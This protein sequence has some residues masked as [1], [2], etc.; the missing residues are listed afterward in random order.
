MRPE[1]PLRL[2]LCATAFVWSP[3]AAFLGILLC[4]AV[5]GRN[6]RTFSLLTTPLML[7]CTAALVYAVFALYRSSYGARWVFI[8]LNGLAA[9][10]A[11]FLVCLLAR[12]FPLPWS[13]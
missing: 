5:A 9:V 2:R 10:L 13:P 4:A 1:P 11:A 7:G 3:L 8:V 12:E 6:P